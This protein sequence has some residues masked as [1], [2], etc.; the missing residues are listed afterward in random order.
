MKKV[1]AIVLL[2]SIVC[3]GKEVVVVKG[4]TLW[5]LCKKHLG[6]PFKWPEIAR[7]NKMRNPHL[8]YPKDK[9][10]FPPHEKDLDRIGRLEQGEV[11]NLFGNVQIQ[12]KVSRISDRVSSYDEVTTGACSKVEILFGRDGLIQLMPNTQIKLKGVEADGMLLLRLIKGRVLVAKQEKRGVRVMT[13]SILETRGN[14]LVSYSLQGITTVSIF[15]GKGVVMGKDRKIEI[16]AGYGNQTDSDGIPQEPVLLLEPPDITFPENGMITGNMKPRFSWGKEADAYYVEVANDPSF[17]PLVFESFPKK[18]ELS[19][20]LKEDLYF[21]RVASIDKKGIIGRFSEMRRFAVERRVG[22]RWENRPLYA[23]KLTRIHQNNGYTY[24]STDSILYFYPEYADNSIGKIR[25]NIDGKEGFYKEPMRLK[26]GK[27]SIVYQAI[28]MLG[29]EAEE[30]NLSIISDGT[31]PQG[32]LSISTPLKNGFLKEDATFTI[33]G[34]D[35]LSGLSRIQVG[36]GNEVFAYLKQAEFS[37]S[38]EGEYQVIWRV[39]DSVGNISKDNLLSFSLDKNGPEIKIVTNPE[40]AIYNKNYMLPDNATITIDASDKP[41]GVSAIFY[42]IDSGKMIRYNGPISI[43]EQGL[44]ILRYKAIDKA[45]NETKD[46]SFS[47]FIQP[48]MH[49]YHK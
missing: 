26:E 5:H 4:D 2:G 29:E 31:P 16:S 33:T 7:Y 49:E 17:I 40:L 3:W 43:K 46:C 36:I 14:A 15:E 28:D 34:S 39:E 12:G 10:L 27:H 6:N 25:L 48:L 32:T 41:A 11:I 21:F 24:I 38:A 35:N 8:I 23:E 30:K 47:V 18:E 20:P 19:W 1:I 9:I 45:G 37:L 13:N 42:Q 44:H 22:I